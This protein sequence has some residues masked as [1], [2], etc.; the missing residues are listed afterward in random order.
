MEYD[1]QTGQYITVGKS[2]GDD[3]GEAKVRFIK[4]NNYQLRKGIWLIARG[5]FYR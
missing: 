5:P 4:K 1:L 3:S 2:C